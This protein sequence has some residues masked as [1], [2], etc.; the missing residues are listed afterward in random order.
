MLFRQSSHQIPNL[1]QALG[2]ILH[3][4]VCHAAHLGVRD[5]PTERLRIDGLSRRPLHE[6]RPREPHER[7]SLHHEDHVRERGQIGPAGHA[8]THDG[9]D[10]RDPQIPP[11]ERVVIE[12]PRRTVLSRE[13][14][15][16]IREIHSG[17]IDQ[18]DDRDSATHREF[19]CAQDL[20]DRLGP[21]RPGLHGRVVRDH[22]ALAAGDHRD[23]RDHAG[24]GSLPFV[25][26]V[27][28]EQ[29][30][31]E[32]MRIRVRELR[33]ALAGGEFSLRVLFGRLVRAAA[34]TEPGLEL[35]RGRAE[36]SQ[37]RTHTSCAR[38]ASC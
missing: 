34:L 2:V 4:V 3:R 25:L 7:S 13:H 12:D 10:L 16:L 11:H 33:D 19:L 1:P 32:E 29:P 30:D 37:S 38:R 6:V 5:R 22:H 31:L 9:G 17:G 35:A 8:L 20:G 26:V 28:D 23:S 27:R 36:L 15:A 24:P 14:P 18:V 21:P